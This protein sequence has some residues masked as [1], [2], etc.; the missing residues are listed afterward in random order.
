MLTGR[1]CH[2][3]GRPPCPLAGVGQV[4]IL[5]LD[6]QLHF[7]QWRHLQPLH[8]PHWRHLLLLHFPQWRHFL[9]S[10]TSN[11]PWLAEPKSMSAS[12]QYQ[13][14][15]CV[16]CTVQPLQAVPATAPPGTVFPC[17]YQGFW[18]P[19]RGLYIIQLTSSYPSAS[20]HLDLY[21]L[22]SIASRSGGSHVESPVAVPPL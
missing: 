21:D 2:M 7:P 11:P 14:C 1:L 5:H 18:T 9:P 3:V 17:S 22:A 8:F 19:R 12:A 10:C 4:G 15:S 13:G 20:S 16:L 6:P